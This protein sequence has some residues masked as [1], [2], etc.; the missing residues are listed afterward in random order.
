MMANI[1]K[2]HLL[3]IFLLVGVN[4]SLHAQCVS[5]ADL[6]AYNSGW[7]NGSN[8]GTTG[9]GP[10]EFSG[11]ISG[12]PFFLATSANLDCDILNNGKAFGICPSTQGLVYAT[13]RFSGNLS[14]G[15]T[16]SLIFDLES[17]DGVDIGFRLGNSANNT[18]LSLFAAN[19]NIFGK[20]DQLGYT[21]A[22]ISRTEDAI[23]VNITYTNINNYSMSIYSLAKDTTIYLSGSFSNVSNQIPDRIIFFS[24][25]PNGK[26][27]LNNLSLL[28]HAIAAETN[29][30]TQTTCQNFTAKTLSVSAYGSGLTYQWYENSTKSTLGATPISGANGSSFT[31]PTSTAGTKYYYCIVSSGSAGCPTIRSNISGAVIVNPFSVSA[32]SD[33]PTVCINNPIPSITHNTIG[34]NGITGNNI[35]GA[36]G[37]PAGVRAVWAANTITISGTPTASGTFNYS[38]PLTG[39]CSLSATGTITVSPAS[40][41]GSIAG[42]NSVCNGTNST[43]L[44]L[45]GLAGTITRWE[46][47]TDNFA[48]AGTS[49]SNTTNTLTATDLT[50]TTSYRAVVTSGVCPSANSTS[51]NIIVSPASIGGT[52][53]G[54]TGVCSGTNSTNLTLSGI[55]GTVTRWESSTD[56][57][58]TVTNIANTSNILT[59]SNLTATTAYRAVV[60]SGVC[61]ATNSSTATITVSPASVG[62]SIAGSTNVCAGTNS[63]TLTLSGITGTVTRWES[64][65]DNFTT[66]TN[67]ANTTN[68]ITPTN[69]TATTAYRA[70]VSSGACPDA[71]SIPAT[72]TVNP[73]SVGGSI[74]G[75]TTVCSGT[76]STILTLSGN[77]GTVIRW[78]SSLDN[79]ATAGTTI[80]NTS[81]TFTAT[82]LTATTSYRAI[83]SSGVCTEVSST[84]ATINVSPA[85]VGGS[86]AGSTT[87]CTGTNS[88]ILTLSGITGTV[89]RWESSQDNFTTATSI[90]NTSNTLTATNLTATNA[91]RAVVASGVC[92][93]VNSTS[94]IITV[95]PASVGGSIAGSTTVCAGTNSTLLTLSGFTGAVTR[96]ESSLD[97][98]ATAGTSIANTTNTLTANNLS[99]TTT[100]RAIVA[101]GACT[102]ANSAS[103]TITVTPGPVGGSISGSTTVCTGTN[104]T[105]L[106]LSGITGAVKQW[107]SSTDNFAT[108]GTSIANTSNTLTITDIIATTSYRAIVSSGTCPAVNSTT[109]TINVSPASVGGTIAGSTTVCTG[110]NSTVLS[111]SGNIGTV[112]RW[113]SSLDNFATAGTSIA[114]TTATL[115]ASNLSAT[116]SYRAVVKS[117]ACAADNS[118]SATIT[119]IPAPVGGSISGSTAVCTGTNSTVLTLSGITGTVNR[120]E[121]STD[122][123]ATAGTAIANTTNTFTATNLTTSTAYRAV[124]TNGACPDANSSTA[125]ITVSPASVGGSVA[126]SNTVC[127]GTNST[128]LTLSGITGTVTRW[129]SSLD[130][131][132]TAGTSIANTSNTLTAPNLTATTSYRAI[133]GSG[134]CAE[135]SSTNAVI[136]VS[137]ASVGG[138]IAGSTTVCT[139]T[140]STVLT[141]IGNTGAVVR[142][143]SSLD[144]FATAGTSIANTSNTLTATDLTTTTSYRAVVASGACAEVNSATASITVSPASVGGTIAG[145][146]TVCT[147]TN[148]TVLTLSGNT[149]AVARWESSLDNFATPGATI[150]N[151][152]N[153]LTATNLTANTSYRAVIASGVCPEVNSA[154]AAI[155]V[156]PAP[157]GGSIAGSTNVCILE[158]S[159]TLTLSGYTGAVTLWES[160]EDNFATAGTSIANTGNTFTATNIKTTT[161]YRAVISSGVCPDANSAT[162]TITVNANP[163]IPQFNPI[164]NLCINS[165]PAPV[166]PTVSND[167]ITGTWSPATINTTSDATYTFTPD[168]GQCAVGTTMD[169]KVVLNPVV[170]ISEPFIQV[171]RGQSITLISKVLGTNNFRWSPNTAIS[172]ENTLNPVVSP[173][174]DITYTLTATTE[175][176]CVSKKSVKIVVLEDLII[177]TAFSPNGDGVN[178]KFVIQ[179]IE[180][181][182]NATVDI[183]NRSG[184][185]LKRY[186]GG[187]T[188]PWDGKIN[189]QD[190]PLGT[191]FYVINPNA[192]NRKILSGSVTIIR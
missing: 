70:V 137:P 112:I 53:A 67:I 161:S 168:P 30:A 84:I 114:N 122:N 56:N 126:G 169:V 66:V 135:A 176:G 158:N 25:N 141:L 64:S 41:G 37:L 20:F 170:E 13:R 47:S 99:A 91:Y 130:N 173:P 74:A 123:F 177:P 97:N 115:T 93:E 82:N 24:D 124:V 96:W 188:L 154:T 138:T 184:Q 152:G 192:G 94:A 136:T 181:Y 36:N 109:A 61:P 5:S 155:T 57:F 98:F 23:K 12:A 8:D 68:T 14:I 165:S 16:I 85:S 182:T 132:A 139:G 31:P 166:L 49:I 146:T 144:N 101:S 125:S 128:T 120:W 65:T 80:A 50:A 71:N 27:Y 143:E 110:T 164:P 52:I 40:V 19:G 89:T 10:W 72:I 26:I 35:A 121:S 153:T 148:S 78:E 75:S 11:N 34:A 22:G 179:N 4:A 9:F 151:T 38:I 77:T 58:T 116:T 134:A 18:L 44:T 73:A 157:V 171:L 79:F 133:V 88:T 69:L 156:T 45:S 100:Y 113:E 183:F 131:F 51:A 178:D 104:S 142:W 7:T 55:T 106:T 175:D 189:G 118:T 3:F 28:N 54:S 42:S 163:V 187:Y 190:V 17:L 150:A 60:T 117:G 160:S 1:F 48:T 102:D 87:V 129:E 149:G 172:N 95:L 119:A 90:A 174:N 111:L 76:N 32:A 191:Y 81:N 103:A 180:K 162:A 43:T 63:T 29:F 92:N 15:N 127:T 6:P 147:G 21:P 167:N 62:G 107:E 86:I 46:S 145:S 159:A 186:V 33:N 2:K 59:A 185:L 105:T 39:G 140:N 83:V 108:A